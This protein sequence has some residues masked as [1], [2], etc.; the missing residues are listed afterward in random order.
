MRDQTDSRT[1]PLQLPP[2]GLTRLELK[3]HDYLCSAIAQLSAAKAAA[4]H[5][6]GDQFDAS[7]DEALDA[8]VAARAM[9]L[10]TAG[11]AD[12]AERTKLLAAFT[13][14]FEEAVRGTVA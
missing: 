3:T 10:G 12:Q 6:C 9:L 2:A 8:V 14:P 1:L 7:L 4:K 13:L 5:Y 11:P